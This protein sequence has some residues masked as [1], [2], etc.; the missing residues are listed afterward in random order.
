MGAVSDIIPPYQ[1]I[2]PLPSIPW[3]WYING[4][5]KCKNTPQNT[6]KITPP[7]WIQSAELVDYDDALTFMEK[8]VAGLQDGTA[9]NTVWL[10]SHPPLYTAGTNAN[11]ADL[12]TDAFPV[13]TS[14]RGGQ[15][16]YHGPG[17]RIAYV[18]LNLRGQAVRTFVPLLE[19]WVMDVLAEL[20]IACQTHCGRVGVW[21]VKDGKQVKIASIGLRISRGY[22]SHGIAINNTPDLSHFGGIVPCGLA[23]YGVTSIADMGVDISDDALDDLM[24]QHFKRIFVT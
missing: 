8:T 14:K 20:G 7:Q 11:P 19:Q 10:L 1:N 9:D 6:L 23:D 5:E 17:Q 15:Y 13:Y 22:T 3:A 24:Q 18:M 21:T 2:P 16:T 4:M 12:L